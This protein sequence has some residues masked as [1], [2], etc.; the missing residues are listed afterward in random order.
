MGSI[1]THAAWR[2]SSRSSSNGQ[3]TEVRDRSVAIDVRDSKDPRG[4]MLTFSPAAWAAFTGSIKD[5][6]ITP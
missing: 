6:V 4:P 5:G 1:P 2:K 3:C